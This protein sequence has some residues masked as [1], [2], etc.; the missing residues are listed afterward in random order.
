MVTF[1]TLSMVSLVPKFGPQRG[2]GAGV[3]RMGLG[4][5]WLGA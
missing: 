3:A 1:E 2:I 4:W 5:F